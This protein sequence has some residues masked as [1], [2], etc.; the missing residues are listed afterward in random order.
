[1]TISGYFQ[2]KVC[3]LGVVE[4]NLVSEN[5]WEVRSAVEK[6]VQETPIRE[7][8]AEERLVPEEPVAKPAENLVPERTVVLAEKYL[9]H[10]ADESVVKANCEAWRKQRA[11]GNG[12]G[13]SLSFQEDLGKLEVVVSEKISRLFQLDTEGDLEVLS[14][15]ELEEGTKIVAWFHE[16]QFNLVPFKTLEEML[17]RGDKRLPDFNQY[18]HTFEAIDE[19]DPGF[20]ASALVRVLGQKFESVKEKAPKVGESLG[21]GVSFEEFD[22]RVRD[23]FFDYVRELEELEGQISSKE[24][25]ELS[26]DYFRND[27]DLKWIVSL[28]NLMRNN[29]DVIDFMNSRKG[30]REAFKEGQ[31]AVD[32]NGKKI[33]RGASFVLSALQKKASYEVGPDKDRIT[34][35]GPNNPM[36]KGKTQRDKANKYH[37]ERRDD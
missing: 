32:E 10:A 24:A 25:W 35:F 6:Q 21:E 16:R 4:N 26:N 22:L 1:M 36:R 23:G 18:E 31:N 37:K 9:P 12:N 15:D 14:G 7:K 20:K 29:K 19:A 13:N 17:K 3:V 8:L 27:G 30:L 28:N 33:N 2:L 11:N 34:P 5:V